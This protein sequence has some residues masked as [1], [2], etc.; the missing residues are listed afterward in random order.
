MTTDDSTPYGARVY[1]IDEKTILIKQTVKKRR[2]QNSPYV[3]DEQKETH[4]DI[5]DDAAIAN[6][7]R[8]AICGQLPKGK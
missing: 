2:D 1:K 5:T 4:V 3:I 8:R 6:A 7:L